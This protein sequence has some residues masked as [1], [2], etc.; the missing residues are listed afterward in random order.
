MYLRHNCTL[1]R[2]NNN[3]LLMLALSPFA[4]IYR[5]VVG[6]KNFLYDNQI[7]TPKEFDM[8]VISIGNI[9]MGGTGKTPH[10][11]LIVDI[12]KPRFQVAVLSR[13]YKRRTSGYLEVHADMTYLQT[14]DE[15]LQM[16][17][18]FGDVV[19]A[20]CENR[21][22]GIRRLMDDYPDLNVVLLD[23]AFQHRRVKP[24][25]S[26]LLNNFHHPLSRDYMLPYGRLRESTTAVERADIIIITK[27]PENMKPMERRIMLK[28]IDPKP[29]QYL[30]FTTFEYHRPLPVFSG[31]TCIF[32]GDLS[33]VNIL[34]VS[35]IAFS[36]NFIDYLNDF[37]A[38]VKHLKFRDHHNFSKKDLLN[39]QA[40]YAQIHGIKCII[41]T[42]KDS[43]RLVEHTDFP[44][45]LKS[46]IFYVPISVKLLG[47]DEEYKQLENQFISYVS[48]NKR[49]SKL[50]KN[51][52]LG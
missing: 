28:D 4:L 2:H 36:K 23:D 1:M 3:I 22:K 25:L 31:D 37:Y 43:V 40:A 19:V 21:A 11:E 41:T 38:S 15:P 8:P 16:K 51:T 52:G 12:L 49:Y 24:G 27:C 13:G 42:E 50:Y 33:K 47:I 30:F 5:M 46:A 48:T 17:R 7:I 29:Y 9:S 39:I 45:D 6:V 26:V 14:G 34:V 44:E 35:G 20:V 18:K 32:D 10:T